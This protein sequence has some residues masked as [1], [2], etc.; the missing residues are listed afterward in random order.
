MPWLTVNQTLLCWLR[1]VPAPVLALEVQRGGMPGQPGAKRGESLIEF[2]SAIR[3]IRSAGNYTGFTTW[4][5][6]CRVS[7]IKQL[8]DEKDANSISGPKNDHRP[9][10]RGNMNRT[11]KSRSRAA[12]LVATIACL[13]STL[14]LAAD[15][16]PAPD[17]VTRSVPGVAE[18]TPLDRGFTG[19]YN[20]DF[21]GAQKDFEAWQT[22][23]P[24][25][26]MGPVSE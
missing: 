16:D 17:A 21:A 13:F 5:C 2:S 9:D 26:P 15:S 1:A 8:V 22:E 23:H 19:L 24:D 10:S 11:F 4:R 7:V 20:L 3:L 6:H 14:L 18:R 12:I 25:D